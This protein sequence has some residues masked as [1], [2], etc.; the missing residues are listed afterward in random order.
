MQNMSN[1]ANASQTLPPSLTPLKRQALMRQIHAQLPQTQC[2]RCGFNDCEAYAQ[3]II[4]GK[5]QINRCQPGGQEGIQRLAKITGLTALPLSPEVGK[6]T[7]RS[8]ALIDENWC[9]GC[10]KC[11]QACPVDAIFGASKFMHVI[12]EEH[13]TGCELCLPAC[14]VDC[15][16][17]KPVT[18]QSPAPTGWSAWSL[19]LAE[20]ARK[21]YT[22]HQ[23][24]ITQLKQKHIS[25]QAE[26]T[27]APFTPS[28]TQDHKKTLISEIIEK[29]KQQQSN[30]KK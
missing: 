18:S 2:Q 24:R 26:K 22:N 7:P 20:N 5:T 8:L 27:S 15:I 30:F 6:E 13:C 28:S 10:T 4:A 11:I 17:L 9:I 3:A 21:R 25:H 12:L 1:T 23:Y 19:H 29:A 14:P 16:T